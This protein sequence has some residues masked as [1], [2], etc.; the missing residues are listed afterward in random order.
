MTNKYLWQNSDGITLITA[1]N[2]H[3]AY[4]I[5]IAN[6]LKRGMD[7]DHAVRTFAYNDLIEEAGWMVDCN[8]IKISDQP[9][10]GEIPDE[11]AA[12]LASSPVMSE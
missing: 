10:E 12:C 3:E 1:T 7:I 11:E 2:I 5:A 4:R 9:Y 8:Y 6:Y